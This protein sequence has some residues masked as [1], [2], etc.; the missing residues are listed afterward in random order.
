MKENVRFVIVTLLKMK[1]PFI[2]LS[3]HYRMLNIPKYYYTWP[4]TI[5]FKGFD[6]VSIKVKIT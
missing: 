3:I 1:I 4:N 6:G 5:K 2:S